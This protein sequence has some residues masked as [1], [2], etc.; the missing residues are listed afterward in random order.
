MEEFVECLPGPFKSAGSNP[1]IPLGQRRPEVLDL[2]GHRRIAPADRPVQIIRIDMEFECPIIVRINSRR[3]A[4]IL[5][6]LDP[7][8]LEFALQL[9]QIGRMV[10]PL[11]R[12]FL[13]S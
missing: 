5:L 13:E 7:C 3:P 11:R 12:K 8:A 4:G 9:F 1:R 10:V 6:V 2:F